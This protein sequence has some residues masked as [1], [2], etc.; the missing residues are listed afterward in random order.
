MSLVSCPRFRSRHVTVMPT[1]GHAWRPETPTVAGVSWKE[2]GCFLERRRR[3][4]VGR[5]VIPE[6]R[7]LFCDVKVKG[8]TKQD[9]NGGSSNN[10]WLHLDCSACVEGGSSVFLPLLNTAVNDRRNFMHKWGSYFFF[11]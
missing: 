10:S 7:G 4:R 1:A 3:R 11:Y 5:W 2:G 8:K 9:F 6:Q